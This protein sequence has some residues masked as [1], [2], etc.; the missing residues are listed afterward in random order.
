MAILLLPLFVG[1]ATSNMSKYK[2]VENTAMRNAPQTYYKKYITMK[3]SFL[4]TSPSMPYFAEKTFSSKKYYMLII[5]PTS[6]RVIAKRNKELDEL[7]ASLKSATPIILYGKVKKF[8]SK[9]FHSGIS[10][11][12]LDLDKIEIDKEAQ[13]TQDTKKDI[14][15]NREE[16]KK[17]RR[18]RILDR[19][20]RRHRRP[21][22]ITD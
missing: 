16:L 10:E 11:Y 18:Q 7:I 2:L 21:N 14:K 15:E 8:S 13:V 9:K 19:K 12:Y 4:G 22:V 6:F 3:T 20:L 1:A 17:E 5:S